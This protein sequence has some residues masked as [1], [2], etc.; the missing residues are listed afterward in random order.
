[1]IKVIYEG[2]IGVGKTSTLMQINKPNISSFEN[3]QDKSN[4]KKII[5]EDA[6][7]LEYEIMM[8]R[9]DQLKNPNIKYYDYDLYKTIFIN[10]LKDMK[11]PKRIDLISKA[12]QL[13]LDL[14]RK[15]KFKRILLSSTSGEI[16]TRIK[17]RNRQYENYNA[18]FISNLLSLYNKEYPF[19][20]KII[21]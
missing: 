5:N 6:L 4:F 14:E 7:D 10:R 3:V 20:Q 11:N 1:M 17:T 12:Y 9:Y 8:N 2:C 19:H 15:F 13:H 16:M 18:E 21:S